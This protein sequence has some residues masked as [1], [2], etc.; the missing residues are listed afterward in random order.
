MTDGVIAGGNGRRLVVGAFEP[1]EIAGAGPNCAL[2][3]DDTGD[4]AD[5]T[6]AHPPEA[7]HR[8]HPHGRVSSET[9]PSALPGDGAAGRDRV[10]RGRGRALE[11]GEARA[12]PIARS[13][14]A[15]L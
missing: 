7:A 9:L 1:A 13:F 8:L 5:S 3:F 6:S 11:R 2:C 14:R 10:T 12:R 4:P 15:L